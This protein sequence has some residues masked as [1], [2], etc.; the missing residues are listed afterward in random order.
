MASHQHD[1]L[2]ALEGELLTE[3][4]TFETAVARSAVAMPLAVVE[5]FIERAIDEILVAFARSTNSP[6]APMV[7]AAL[8]RRLREGVQ[9]RLDDLRRSP[10]L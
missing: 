1:A 8:G 9:W 6:A 7:H 2:S 10:E 4:R 5:L 3:F